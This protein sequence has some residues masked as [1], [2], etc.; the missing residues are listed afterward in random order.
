MK[1]R[2]H[3]IDPISGNLVENPESAPFLLEGFGEQAL[4]IYFESR[5][6]RDEFATGAVNA[7]QSTLVDAFRDPDTAATKR[8]Q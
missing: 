3:R 4:K 1:I 5:A 2:E 8:R 7:P 6:N